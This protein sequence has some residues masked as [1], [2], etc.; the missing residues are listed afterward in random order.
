MDLGF[1]YKQVRSEATGGVGGV[2]ASTIV[3]RLAASYDLAGDGRYVLHA[4]Y[5]HY[6]SLYNPRT[7]AVNTNV[8]NPDDLI[9]IYTGPPGAGR[10]FAPGFDPSNYLTVAGIFPT[11]NVFLKD[12]LSSTLKQEFTGSGDMAVG[13]RGHAKLTYIN[14]RLDTF[15]EDFVDLTTGETTIIRDGQNFG[16]FSSQVYRNS[17]V[18]T[19][20]YLAVQLHA[21]QRINSRWQD[22]GH[23]TVQVEND[24]NFEGEA[25]NCPGTP[26]PFGDYPEIFTA[27]RHYPTGPLSSFQP[28][29]LPV[30]SLYDLGLGGSGD[31]YLG[32]LW[33]YNSSQAYNLDATR[34]PLSAVQGDLTAACASRPPNQTLFFGDRGSEWFSGYGLLDLSVNLEIPVWQS[35]RPWL[36][37][38]MFNVLSNDSL[39]AWHTTVRPD[40]DSPK[41]RDTPLGA[42]RGSER[43]DPGRAP[44]AYVWGDALDELDRRAPDVREIHYRMHCV[45][46]PR[47]RPTEMLEGAALQSTSHQVQQF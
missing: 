36:K 15:V 18:P 41:L 12:G 1:R 22:D 37:V 46:H 19:R 47:T 7:F 8:G 42:R 40:P 14:Q 2:D 31:V 44:A 4:T 45:S 43:P 30:W 28:H 26:S 6:A 34:Q 38:E 20:R 13:P 5:G 24:G 32:A 39:I 25:R 35:L 27:A 21:Q 3:P 9:R 23:W 29:K 17:D 10:D 16:T 11:D 33:R